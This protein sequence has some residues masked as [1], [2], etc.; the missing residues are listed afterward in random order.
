MNIY[1]TVGQPSHQKISP[2]P[3]VLP[4]SKRSEAMEHSGRSQSGKLGCP[5]RKI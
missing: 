1:L 3:L 4:K 2:H 5:V